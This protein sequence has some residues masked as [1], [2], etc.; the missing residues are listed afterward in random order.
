MAF[1]AKRQKIRDRGRRRIA[2]QPTQAAAVANAGGPLAPGY[3]HT[4]FI[5]PISRGAGAFSPSYSSVPV[6]DNPG[7][8]FPDLPG[9][10]P[11]LVW[12][13]FSLNTIANPG[14]PIDAP[15]TDPL[16]SNFYLDEDYS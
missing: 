16:L 13:R 2:M 7:F 1:G 5:K 15:G 8:A 4:H 3:M 9:C 14:F 10:A 11:P 12:D 6:I